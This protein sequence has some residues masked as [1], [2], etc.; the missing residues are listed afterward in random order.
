MVTDTQR[1]VNNLNGMMRRIADKPTAP[2]SLHLPSTF[3][4]PREHS[5]ACTH[6]PIIKELKEPVD[7]SLEPWQR[8]NEKVVL[9]DIFIRQSDAGKLALV[10]RVSSDV[11][12][13]TTEFDPSDLISL[14]RQALNDRLKSLTHN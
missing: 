10:R 12:G 1:S 14:N 4:Q 2:Q 6:I 11:N 9:Y 3:T 7:K 13:G 5:V 8:T